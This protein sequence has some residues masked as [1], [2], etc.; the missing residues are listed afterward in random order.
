MANVSLN[1]SAVSAAAERLFVLLDEPPEIRDAPG[2][3]PL[4]GIE[5]RIAFEQVDFAYRPITACSASSDAHRPTRGGCCPGGAIRRRKDHGRLADPAF[6]RGRRRGRPH[7]RVRRPG[8][9]GR[10][11]ARADWVSCP[12]TLISLPA[13]SATTSPTGGSRRPMR[14]LRR[15]REPPTPTS[16]FWAAAGRLRDPGSGSVGSG[17]PAASASDFPSRGPS[18]ATHVS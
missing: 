9:H 11:P 13:R 18:S 14:R 15:P 12:R 1:L 4:P 6:L 5:G 17:F 16:S 2:A 8:G 3:R 10:D 7:R